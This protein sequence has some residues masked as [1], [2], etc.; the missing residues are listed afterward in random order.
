MLGSRNQ[1]GLSPQE[2]E[3]CAMAWHALTS[4]FAD[5]IDTS[6]AAQHSS[7]THFNETREVVFLGA[8]AYPASDASLPNARLSMLACL[9]HELAHFERYKLGYRRPTN[10]PGSLL[11]E[12]ETS[13]RASFHPLLSAR[14]RFDLIEDARDRLIDWVRETAHSLES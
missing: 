7:R 12:A 3:R 1:H 14:D 6:R 5:R 11:D 8:N 10:N 4:E 2:I 9:A 13:I